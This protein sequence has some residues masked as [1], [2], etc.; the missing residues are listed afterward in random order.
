MMWFL[1]LY[2]LIDVDYKSFLQM[3]FRY[4]LVSVDLLI[5]IDCIAWLIT[6]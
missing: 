1:N 3:L 5:T 6:D 2:D 4:L